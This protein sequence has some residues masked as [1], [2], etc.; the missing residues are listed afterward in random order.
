MST[1]CY[2]CQE[3][4][5]HSCYD[6]SN[7]ISLNNILSEAQ[8]KCVGLV[9]G[10]DGGNECPKSDK[11]V[12]ENRATNFLN[13]EEGKSCVNGYNSVRVTLAGS[14]YDPF[15]CNNQ[16]NTEYCKKGQMLRA[17]NPYY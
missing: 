11:T 6:C 12:Y 2:R 1:E 13:S 10:I 16:S 4:S 8:M 9:G 14:A 7:D 17:P 15:Y 5:K 3:N